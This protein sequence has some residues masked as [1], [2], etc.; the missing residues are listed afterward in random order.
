MNTV[1][2]INYVNIDLRH[3]HGISVPELQMF[4]CANETSPAAK[5]KEK[6]L[7]SQATKLPI[8]PKSLYR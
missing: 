8:L 6:L 3:Q 7:F 1:H 2:I 5:S 4:L